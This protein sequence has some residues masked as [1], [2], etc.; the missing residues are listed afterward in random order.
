MHDDNV[1]LTDKQ[2][3]EF[4]GISTGTIRNWRILGEGPIFT[5][6]GPKHVRYRLR[7]INEWLDS[8]RFRSTSEYQEQRRP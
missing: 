5:K 1:L 6:I 2:A 8:R 3:A 7:D 4:M